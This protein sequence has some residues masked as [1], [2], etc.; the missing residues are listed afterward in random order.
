V[1]EVIG[2]DDNALNSWCSQNGGEAV[3][4]K[5]LAQDYFTM[6]KLNLYFGCPDTNTP[7]QTV[8]EQSQEISK[9]GTTTTSPIF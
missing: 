2:L 1:T 9:I 6:P 3:C 5:I 4:E 8:Q 7:T